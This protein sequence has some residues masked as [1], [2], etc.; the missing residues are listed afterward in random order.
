MCARLEVDVQRPTS[1]ALAGCGESF[2]FGVQLACRVVVSLSSDTS[3]DVQHNRAHHRVRA[4]PVVRL[5]RKL[6]GVRGPVQVNGPIV[7]SELQSW[8]YTRAES[9]HRVINNRERSI[10]NLQL[11]SALDP[12]VFL[13]SSVS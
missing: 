13:I 12:F 11:P 3:F 1:G 4:R 6:D 5:A 8:Q 7:V 2:L 10:E 9:D